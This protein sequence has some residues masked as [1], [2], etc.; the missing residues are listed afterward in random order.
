MVFYIY[1]TLG[2]DDISIEDL[3]QSYI[4]DDNDNGDFY[5]NKKK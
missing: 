2:A 4:V 5:Q 1:G 3:K